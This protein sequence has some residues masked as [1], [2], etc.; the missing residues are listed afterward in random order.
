MT[1]FILKQKKLT[2]THS[3]L[4]GLEG[5]VLYNNSNRPMYSQFKSYVQ[6]SSV[7]KCDIFISHN[8]PKDIHDENN[9]AHEG[10]KTLIDYIKNHKPK[11]IFYG[12]QHINKQAIAGTTELFAELLEYM[13]DGYLI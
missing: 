3:T 5:F 4:G 11:Y 6:L 13:E 10:F 1:I 9:L 8:S 12:Q 2:I 7:G